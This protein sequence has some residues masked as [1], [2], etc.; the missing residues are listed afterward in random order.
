LSGT[1]GRVS[2][3]TIAPMGTF[4]KKIHC[5]PRYFVRIPPRSTPTAA[6]DPPRAPQ[7][8]SALLRSA[9]S[10]NV[11]VTIDSAAGEMIAAPTPCTARDAIRTP[12]LEESPQTSDASVNRI[13][14]PT[15][16]RRRPRRSAMRPPRSRKP[17]KV[18]AYAVST[19]CT[20]DSAIFRS[21]WIDGIA[22]LTI[23]TSRIVMKNA[24]PT[25][26]RTSHFDLGD[27]LTPRS[28]L[29]AEHRPAKKG[30]RRD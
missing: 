27:A 11:V 25:T 26:A 17:P 16:I 18:I 13:S 19:H 6:P 4:T 28:N 15:K 3:N 20:V 14:P 23:D 12:A 2:A 1:I 21:F 29:P 24:V 30:S 10:S 22:T 7:M 5:Q 9:P 8:P